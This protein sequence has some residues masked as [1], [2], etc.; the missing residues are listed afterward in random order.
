[1]LNQQ[2]LYTPQHTLVQGINL[3]LNFCSHFFLSFF[4]DKYGN[5]FFKWYPAVN[6][7]TLRD[8]TFNALNET[9]F[10]ISI[11][12]FSHYSNK[13]HILS[14]LCLKINWPLPF[15]FQIVTE[16]TISIHMTLFCSLCVGSEHAF[17]LRTNSNS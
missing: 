16:I 7:L 2:Q 14:I 1:M 8:K 15:F 4:F 13:L 10:P 3:K 17:H 11:I 12:I 6:K 9:S 5:L